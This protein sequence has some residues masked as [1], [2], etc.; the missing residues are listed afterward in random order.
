MIHHMCDSFYFTSL[1]KTCRTTCMCNPCSYAW[2]SVLRMARECSAWASAVGGRQPRAWQRTELLL[3]SLGDSLSSISCFSPSGVVEVVRRWSGLVNPTTT[4]AS[5]V[6]DGR[7]QVIGR[8]LST[9]LASLPRPAPSA[10]LRR[11]GRLPR[12]EGAAAQAGD[13]DFYLCWCDS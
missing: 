7:S 9:E 8:R 4:T 10:P 13:W 6:A 12:R 11:N 5:P 2:M 1:L 3:T